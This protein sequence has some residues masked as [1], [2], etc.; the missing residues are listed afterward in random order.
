[1]K[2][3]ATLSDPKTRLQIRNATPADVPAICALSE[4]VYAEAGMKGYSAG[5]IT[6]QINIFPEGQF[7]I[8]VDDKIVGYC[9]T[10]ITR[11]EIAL[12]PHTWVEITG[13]GYAARHDPDGDWLYGMEVFVDPDYRGYHLGQRLYNQRKK[14]CEERKLEGIV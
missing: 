9:A 6:G 4:R 14:L 5:A 7:V 13:N 12:K 1:M 3:T 11:G 10:F 8:T 2:N